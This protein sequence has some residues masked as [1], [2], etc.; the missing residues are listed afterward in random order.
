MQRQTTMAILL[1]AVTLAAAAPAHPR[2]IKASTIVPVVKKPD[3]PGCRTCTQ[4][5]ASMFA[6]GDVE[7]AQRL[8]RE[9]S[10]KCPSSAQLHLLLSTILIRS[11]NHEEAEKESGIAA[12]L[13]PSLLAAH[14]Q[15][16]LTLQALN[17]NTQAAAEFE[18]VV[19][20][21]PS[22]YEAWVALSSLYR[23]LREDEKATDAAAKAADLDPH[24]RAL[25]MGT[26]L[27]LKKA[28]K[29]EQA[30][31]EVKRLLAA[32]S[33]TPEFAEELAREAL[34]VGGY[35]EA[36]DGAA[37]DIAAHPN[38][39]APLF[40]S[41][42]AHYCLRN[43]DAAVIDADRI[44]ALEPHNV[45]A[46][47]LKALAQLK[48]NKPEEA[49]ATLKTVGADTNST[50]YWLAKG[51][52]EETR[53]DLPAAEEAL[54]TCLQFDQGNNQMQGIPHSLAHLALAELYQKLSKTAQANEQLHELARDRR[55]SRESSNR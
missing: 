23:Q 39:P 41:A 11:G 5:A 12:T 17:R 8:L 35:D 46:Q 10:P 50:M 30:R 32:Q 13:N 2:G 19:Q 47:A 20:L 44:I 55:F 15:H 38:S 26:L 37:K 21:D 22:S 28:G 33:T 48:A 29:F 1:T 34:L 40:T 18:K 9:W 42:L 43:Y 52:I 27:N 25:K 4:E 6:R 51:S 54:R 24:A 49:D 36:L 16:A 45:D 3:D 14:L 31:L 53:S 7:Q